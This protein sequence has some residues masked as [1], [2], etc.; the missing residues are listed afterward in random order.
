M[1]VVKLRFLP[2]WLLFIVVLLC[3][4]WSVRYQ[5][6][7]IPSQGTHLRE[8]D[9]VDTVILTKGFAATQGWRDTGKWWHGSW[10]AGNEVKFYRP[11]TSLVFYIQ[12]RAFG[13]HGRHQF[14]AVLLLLHLVVLVVLFL[15]LSDLFD[16]RMAALATCLFTL[17]AADIFGFPSPRF[18]LE[19]WKDQPEALVTLP[20]IG[21]LWCLLRYIRTEYSGWLFGS[22][23]VFVLAILTKEMAYTLPIMAALLLWHGGKFKSHWRILILFF[24]LAIALFLFRFWALQGMGFRYGSNDS[25]FYRWTL[26]MMGGYPLAAIYRGDTLPLAMVYAGVGG[27]LALRRAFVAAGCSLVTAIAIY[28]VTDSGNLQHN[29]LS[30]LSTV[31]LW[32][33]VA[34]TAALIFIL[35]RFFKR[36]DRNQWFGWLFVLIAYIPLMGFHVTSHAWYLPGIGWA[37]FFAYAIQDVVRSMRHNVELPAGFKAVAP[38]Q[39]PALS[40]EEGAQ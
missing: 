39:P 3:G 30:R 28:F 6:I 11:I 10:I 7:G 25:W 35:F 2:S 13:M 38:K 27:V 16:K 37:I 8:W 17:S 22:L 9:D 15:F 12:Y 34:L 40:V 23:G 18:A 20:Y 33:Y 31:E 26:N 1:R 4:V 19:V 36:R 14:T 29:I 32:R 24:G 21:S 5:A